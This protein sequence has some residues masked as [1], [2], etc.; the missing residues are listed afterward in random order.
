LG[1]LRIAE[2]KNK[3]NFENILGRMAKKSDQK[4]GKSDQKRLVYG[5]GLVVE[6]NKT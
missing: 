3:G 4:V 6:K 2:V 5:T 1:H